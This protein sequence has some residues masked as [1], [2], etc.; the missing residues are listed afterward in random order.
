MQPIT[1]MCSGPPRG[2]GPWGGVL[3]VQFQIHDIAQGTWRLASK[4]QHVASARCTPRAEALMPLWFQ[5]A[6]R[7]S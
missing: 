6:M 3:P 4:G 1:Q 7:P 5:G 2:E